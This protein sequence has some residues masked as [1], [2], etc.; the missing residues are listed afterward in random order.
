MYYQQK[1]IIRLVNIGGQKKQIN[2]CSKNFTRK[3]MLERTDCRQVQHKSLELIELL[4]MQTVS[5]V[6][7]EQLYIKASKE[8][9]KSAKRRC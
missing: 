8:G 4:D 7:F 1:E 5:L 3:N 6:R 2:K 9:K